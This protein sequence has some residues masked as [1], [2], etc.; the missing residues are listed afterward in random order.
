MIYNQNNVILSFHKE[1]LWTRSI[2]SPFFD[3]KN[4]DIICSDVRIRKALQIIKVASDRWEVRINWS[5]INMT[6]KD[7]MFDIRIRYAG[8][9]KIIKNVKIEYPQRSIST[10]DYNVRISNNC[11]IWGT[12]G[13]LCS[14]I[15]EK[16]EGVESWMI[17]ENQLSISFKLLNGEGF[18]TVDDGN[19]FKSPLSGCEIPLKYVG[20]KHPITEKET[21]K[22]CFAINGMDYNFI[23]FTFSPRPYSYVANVKQLV[24][25]YRYGDSNREIF[26]VK[27]ERTDELSPRAN[28]IK[29]STLVSVQPNNFYDYYDIQNVDKNGEIWKISVNSRANYSTLSTLSR[30]PFTFSFDLDEGR[31]SCQVQLPSLNISLGNKPDL[32]WSPS[33]IKTYIGDTVECI[34]TV[35]NKCDSHIHI[36]E[37]QFDSASAPLFKL[38]GKELVDGNFVYRYLIDISRTIKLQSQVY[39]KTIETEMVIKSYSIYVMER[40]APK[41]FIEKVAENI[42]PLIVGKEYHSGEVF[43]KCRIGFAKDCSKDCS[44]IDLSQISF[45]NGIFKLGSI[46]DNKQ[47]SFPDSLEADIIFNGDKKIN[48]IDIDISDKNTSISCTWNYRNQ[49]GVIKVPVL[50]PQLYVKKCNY[51]K[52]RVDFPGLKD[53][54]V[55]PIMELEFREIA[56]NDTNTI[57][58]SNQFLMVES[59]FSFC[60]DKLLPKAPITPGTKII[61]YLHIDKIEGINESTKNI[62]QEQTLNF[63]STIQGDNN[64]SEPINYKVN[65]NGKTKKLIP[66]Q[67]IL[68]PIEAK[69]KLKV[70]FRTPKEEVRLQMNSNTTVPIEILSQGEDIEAISIGELVFQ[71][72]EKVPYSDYGLRLKVKTITITVGDKDVFYKKP[73]DKDSFDVKILNGEDDVSIPLYIDYHQWKSVSDGKNPVLKLELMPSDNEEFEKVGN[74]GASSAK[75]V[76]YIATLDLF[77]QYIDDVYSLDLGTTGIVVARESEDEPE[78]IILDDEKNPIEKDKEILSSHIMIIADNNESSIVLAPAADEYYLN[79]TKK[80]HFRLVPSKFIIGQERI[81]FLSQFYNDNDLEKNIKLFSFEG[82]SLN[83]KLTEKSGNEEAISKLIASLYKEIF[84]RCKKE[85]GNIKKLIITYPNTYTL[86][87]LDGI[88]EIMVQE[89][90]LNI[91]GQIIFVPESDAV[92]AYYFNQKILFDHGFLDA[93]RKVR[94]EENVIF[95]DMGAGTLDLSY[96]SF[97][98]NENDGITASIVN[99]IGIP[100]AGN[101]LDYIIFKTLLDDGWVKPDMENKHNA[102]KEIISDIKKNYSDDRTIGDINPRWLV[103]HQESFWKKDELKEKRYNDVFDNSIKEYIKVCSETALKSL[104]PTDKKIHTVVFSGRG[105]QFV[106]LKKEVVNV[107]NEISG[108]NVKED[109]LKPTN[110][111]GDHMKT[112]VAIGAIK[113]QSYFNTKGPFR[114]ENKNLYSKIAVVYWGKL[115][116]NTY[117]VVVRYLIE[118]LKDNWDGVEKI[119]G[120][121]CKEF[122]AEET[123]TNHLPGKKMYYIQTCLDEN[124]LKRI[125]RKMYQTE[126]TSQDDLEWAFVNLL[127]KKK[128]YNSDPIQIV[129]KISKEN[130]IIE[131][132]IGTEILTDRKLL[133]NVEDNILYRRSMWPFITTLK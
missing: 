64:P 97:K 123:I 38:I 71:N 103:E 72:L 107:L 43:A 2:I 49:D 127:F 98:K 128:V 13:K 21:K 112:C 15:I 76:Q 53:E 132:K 58:D 78:C 20:Y 125:Y 18:T 130:I 31:D 6:A 88:K 57:W 121:Y 35:K 22:I 30:C 17:K 5:Q 85:I 104:I 37:V 29:I 59:P 50:R 25:V 120:T 26:S 12:K 8:K 56:E 4:I 131:R 79:N 118:P 119:N 70:V 34:L 96:V 54:R 124:N 105:S 83:L 10:S 77:M 3:E 1:S 27:L 108:E 60:K 40:P 7:R 81:P 24:K 69:P 66:K 44:P 110:N 39:V 28:V 63:L 99:K 23:S 116:D 46:V 93:N 84:T 126:S 113:Y 95:Y 68:R 52:E 45:E 67:V 47:L 114:I 74:T 61:Y 87:H 82:E 14:L 89:L 75:S 11:G 73:T 62:F 122:Y 117:D 33:E 101:Y 91:K 129:L 133:E 94:D 92:A 90:G 86:E 80:K 48:P 19:T 65:E 106:P 109:R 55:I 16:K 102:V 42:S 36:S 51:F 115:P 32:L 41:I 100:L 111:C 9:I